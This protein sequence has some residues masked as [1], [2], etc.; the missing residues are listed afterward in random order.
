M[1]LTPNFAL[2]EFVREGESIAPWVLTNVKK[3]AQALQKVRDKLGKPIIVTS[4]YRSP[5]H[6]Q[7]VGGARLSYHMKGL[8]VDFKVPGMTPRQVAVYFKD[9]PGGLGIY[10]GH[11]HADLRPI[12]ARWTG[13]S[14]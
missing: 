2:S 11:V 14:H 4:G 9:W 6:N 3:L 5:A 12:K 8:G 1:Q 7:A 13:K 10:D